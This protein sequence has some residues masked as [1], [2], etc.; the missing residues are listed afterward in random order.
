MNSAERS[1]MIFSKQRKGSRKLPHLTRIHY[2][3]ATHTFR[4]ASFWDHGAT[5]VALGAPGWRA[6]ENVA[7]SDVLVTTYMSLL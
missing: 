5:S 4:S 2:W 1:S 6:K 7:N 3:A